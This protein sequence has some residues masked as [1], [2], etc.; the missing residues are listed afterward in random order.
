[1]WSL[2]GC[3]Y[4]TVLH[5][6]WI[7]CSGT[8][9]LTLFSDQDQDI[10][11]DK[12]LRKVLEY[13]SNVYCICPVYGSFIFGLTRLTQPLIGQD[14]T[15]LHCDWT[16]FSSI[17]QQCLVYGSFIYEFNTKQQINLNIKPPIALVRASQCCIV[18]GQ[19]DLVFTNNDS[20]MDPLSLV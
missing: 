8:V 15:V 13:F 9:A 3:V 20:S 17:Y 12:E 1:M 6:Y 4:C 18:I 16:K 2:I 10:R 5:Y 14:G 19:N 7:N 11:I